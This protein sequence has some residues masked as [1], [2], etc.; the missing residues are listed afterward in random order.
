[1]SCCETRASAGQTYLQV[2]R[3]PALTLEPHA[4]DP[5]Y[6]YVSLAGPGAGPV[7]FALVTRPARLFLPEEGDEIVL[8]EARTIRVF[9]RVTGALLREFPY[10]EDDVEESRRMQAEH[11]RD[12]VPPK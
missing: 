3:A 4:G 9:H 10:R 8:Q 12:S 2:G 7:R 1:M 6:A 11:A 5:A